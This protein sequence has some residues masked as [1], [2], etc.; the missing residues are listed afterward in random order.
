MTK[1]RILDFI[2]KPKKEVVNTNKKKLRR[3]VSER[4]AKEE[5]DEDE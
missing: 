2:P 3:R 4:H 1:I 5:A